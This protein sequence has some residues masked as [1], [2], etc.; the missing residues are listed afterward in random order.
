MD[1]HESEVKKNDQYVYYVLCENTTLKY[2]N[3]KNC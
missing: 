2:K 3:N 1:L